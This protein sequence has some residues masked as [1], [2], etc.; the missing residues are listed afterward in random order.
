MRKPLR[1]I[2]HGQGWIESG[3]GHLGALR[4]ALVSDQPESVIAAEGKVRVHKL[5]PFPPK[6]E[7]ERTNVS[8][9]MDVVPLGSVKRRK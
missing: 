7:V 6:P 9:V 5:E 4:D 2:L 8:G 1:R 3:P